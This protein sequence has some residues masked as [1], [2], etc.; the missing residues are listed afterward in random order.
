MPGHEYGKT[1]QCIAARQGHSGALPRDSLPPRSE[2]ILGDYAQA[3][4]RRREANPQSTELLEPHAGAFAAF[5]LTRRE[6]L[7]QAAAVERDATS[8]LAGG[9]LPA[10]GTPLAP[11]TPFEKTATDYAATHLTPEPHVMAFQGP[12]PRGRGARG[13][14]AR[15]RAA[16]RS[17]A[18]AGHV[19]VRQRPGTPN[20][21]CFLTLEDET[22]TVNAV[23]VPRLCEH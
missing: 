9:R 13:A 2:H 14:R 19:I 18:V 11:M 22:G 1:R 10:A 3:R 5:G 23:V 4:R 20:G 8:L 21:F 16:R 15:R 6:A 17:G 7:W 12:S